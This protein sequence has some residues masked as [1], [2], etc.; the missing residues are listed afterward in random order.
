VSRKFL[1]AER[2][3]ALDG[4]STPDCRY[5]ACRSCGVCTL[6][7]RESNL[8]RQA[9]AHE[10]VP[11]INRATRDQEDP[12]HEPQ[13]S[14]AGSALD[15]H[16]KEQRFRLWYSKTGP[17]MFLS[18]LELQ[19]IFERA[20]RRARLPLAFSSGFHPA[21]LLSFA[22]ALPVGVGSVCEWMDFFVREHLDASDLPALLGSELPQG[23]RVVKVEELTCQ[24]RAPISNRERFSLSFARVEDATRF[25]GRLPGFLQAVQ[26]PVPKLTK[27]GEPGEVDVRPM[28]QSIAAAED[29]FVIDFDWETLYVSPIF[30]LQAVDPEFTLL[31]GRLIKTAQFF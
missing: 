4:A 2:R 13:E 1:L 24:R 7:G 22:R 28:V 30:V 16:N 12:V 6:D 27:K 14:S 29:G 5:E 23:M 20:F 25:A 26:W 15:L 17:A 31:Q 3:R 10:I 8:A 9:A 18:Q 11:V 21:P 19:R